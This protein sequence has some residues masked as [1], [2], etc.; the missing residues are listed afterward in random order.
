M[1]AALRLNTWVKPGGKIE[2]ADTQLPAGKPVDVIILFP[3]Q[4]DASPRSVVDI[5]AEAPGHLVFPSVEEVD[6]YI[7]E[8]REAWER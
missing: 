6:T 2:V 1:Q 4:A 5:L 7:Q 3:Q 8:E